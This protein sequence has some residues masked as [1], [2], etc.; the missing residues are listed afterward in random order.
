MT[1][2]DI[3]KILIRF[4]NDYFRQENIRELGGVGSAVKR[5]YFET[6][7][8]RF[9]NYT[10]VKDTALIMNCTFT[11]LKSKRI[12]TYGQITTFY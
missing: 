4:S 8:S 11:D 12:R 1:H 10:S 5:S 2:E 3:T 9:Q 7:E 6:A